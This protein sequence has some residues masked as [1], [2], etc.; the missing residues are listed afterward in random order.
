MYYNSTHYNVIY[1]EM[2]LLQCND[3]HIEYKSIQKSHLNLTTKAAH[4]RTFL[5]NVNIR[6]A[7][8]ILFP[9]AL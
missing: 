2:K 5:Y 3:I 1:Y 6:A 8:L 9:V 4:L 7:N